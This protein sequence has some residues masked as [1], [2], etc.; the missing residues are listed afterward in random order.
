MNRAELHH[1]FESGRDQ[2]VVSHSNL[3]VT[4]VLV[5]KL[6]SINIYRTVGQPLSPISFQVRIREIDGQNRIVRAQVRPEQS[7]PLVGQA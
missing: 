7:E 1:W 5:N 6:G 4:R 3:F 2:A